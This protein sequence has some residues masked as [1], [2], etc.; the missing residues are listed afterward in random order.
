LKLV[1]IFGRNPE[2]L[3]LLKITV[4]TGFYPYYTL[5]AIGFSLNSLGIFRVGLRVIS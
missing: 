5:F 1:S 3:I 4:C 2:R